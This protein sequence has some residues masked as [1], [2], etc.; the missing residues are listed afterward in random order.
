MLWADRLLR[1]IGLDFDV[2]VSLGRDPF[3]RITDDLFLGSR[4]VEGSVPALQDAGITHVFS[5]LAGHWRSELAFL[6]RSFRTHFEPL[7]DGMHEDV[8]EVLPVFFDFV[9]RARAADPS[10]RV[11]VHC[12]VGVSRSATLATALVMHRTR[13]RFFDAFQEVRRHRPEVLPNIGFASQL[14]RFE[15]QI[16]PSGRVDSGVSSLARY[17]KEVCRVPVEIEVLEE[18][19]IREGDDAVAAIRSVFGG[20]IPRVV[21]GVRV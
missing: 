3:N 7:H 14:Q 6:D 17:L 8:A 13:A 15:H 5:C 18:A 10:A 12:Q 9:D 21:Q 20:E 4:P 16:H 2:D 19:L 1:A 11:L